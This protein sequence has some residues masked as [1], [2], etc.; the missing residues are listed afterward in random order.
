MILS[1]EKK[2]PLQSP[3]LVI[4]NKAMGQMI[5]ILVEFGRTPS[6]RSRVH[7]AR[8]FGSASVDSLRAR[9]AAGQELDDFIASKPQTAPNSAL[10]L[11]ELA[12]RSRNKRPP[13]EDDNEPI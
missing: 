13:G 8:P 4:A 6:S 3:Y 2:I 9:S 10:E 7:I 1:P 5:K 11:L 12:R